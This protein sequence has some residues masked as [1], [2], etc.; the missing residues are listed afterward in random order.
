MG[1]DKELLRQTERFFKEKV[2]SFGATFQGV[3]WN[4]TEAQ[5]IRYDQLTKLFSQE[6]ERD[7]SVCDYGCGYGYYLQYLRERGYRC[8][9]TGM[10]LSESMIACANETYGGRE[11][12]VFVQ[13]TKFGQTYDYIVESGIFNVRQSV[14]ADV[15]TDYM[16]EIIET[17]HTHSKKGFAF[18]C[19]TGYS[20]AEHMREDLYYADPLFWFDYAKRHF[21]QNVA[22]L[23]DYGLYDFTIIVRK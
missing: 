12:A 3:G 18:N 5:R 15:W 17:F 4:S 7:F 9:Y 21:S 2:E 8:S 23:H 16:M 1:E 11:D 19:L 20:D 6:G 14:E 10:D 22:L 13:G